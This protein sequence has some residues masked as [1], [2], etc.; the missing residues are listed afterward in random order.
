MGEVAIWSELGNLYTL[1]SEYDAAIDA[2]EKAL[3]LDG[4]NPHIYDGLAYAYYKKG[5][6][7]KAQSFFEKAMQLS[8][9]DKEKAGILRHLGDLHV[10]LRKYRRAAMVYETADLFASPATPL[11]PDS[12]PPPA[13]KPALVTVP[14]QPTAVPTETESGLPARSDLRPVVVSSGGLVR[15][16]SWSAMPQPIGPG[17]G[18]S[19]DVGGGQL[20]A[21]RQLESQVDVMTEQPPLEVH[22]AAPAQGQGD[23]Q[24]QSAGGLEGG[25]PE[26]S[27]KDGREAREIEVYR[28][29]TQANPSNDRAWFTLGNNLRT[30]GKVQEAIDAYETALALNPQAEAYHFE[31]GT[32]L[33]SLKQYEAAIKEFEE[34]VDLAPDNLFA[35]AALASCLRRLG[36]VGGM[37][38][39]TDLIAPRMTQESNYNRACFESICGN[40]DRAIQ[41]LKAAVANDGVTVEMLRADPDLEFVREAPAFKTLLESRGL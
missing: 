27:P 18:A 40:T 23:V 17:E 10:G 8:E 21:S 35:Q 20:G 25:T 36:D 26:S 7:D 14:P 19:R 34:V 6:Y 13:A 30:H 29:I 2:F 9:D 12:T 37:R 38:R 5:L 1:L 11:D 24:V 39:H 31:L 28:M 4:E 41:L 22:V 3:S 16:D 15:G 32:A 33:A